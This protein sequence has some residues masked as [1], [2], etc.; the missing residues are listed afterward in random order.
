MR[1]NGRFWLEVEG[2]P[3]LGVGRVEL[4][5]QVDTLGSL[6]KAAK[7]MNMSYKAAWE[8]LNEVNTLAKYPVI[9]KSIGGK[10]GGGTSLTPYAFELIATYERFAELYSA[11]INRFAEA[12]DDFE[13]LTRVLKRTFLTT[14]ARNQILC[15]VVDIKKEGLGAILVLKTKLH[16][17]C[18]V[19]QITTKSIEEMGISVGSSLYAIIKSSDISIVSDSDC[20]KLEANTFQAVVSDIATHENTTEVYLTTQE[21]LELVVMEFQADRE[22][23]QG[24]KICIAIKYANILV[25]I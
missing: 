13:H 9:E 24:N 5:R 12:G 23:I 25:G 11:F 4:L 22:I 1:I 15:D 6:H 16:G 19:S 8:R 20:N 18:L 2:K 10:G 17:V 3:F 21:G 7:A 14:S